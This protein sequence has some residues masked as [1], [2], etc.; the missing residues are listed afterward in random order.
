MCGTLDT[1]EGTRGGVGGG[2]AVVF[3]LCLHKRV[4]RKRHHKRRKE[5]LKTQSMLLESA[6]ETNG[7]HVL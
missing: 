6:A 7:E 2:G 3:S 1:T 4:S 5:T